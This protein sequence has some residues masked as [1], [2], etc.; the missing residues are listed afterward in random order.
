MDD[1]PD[2]L[3]EPTELP[4]RPL[5]ERIHLATLSVASLLVGILGVF[6]A[7]TAGTVLWAFLQRPRGVPLQGALVTIVM[8]LLSFVVAYLLRWCLRRERQRSPK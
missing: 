2:W 6:L 1:R 3:P 7:A 4:R 8:S 5:G